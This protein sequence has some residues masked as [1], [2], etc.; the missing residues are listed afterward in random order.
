MS[1]K[2]RI[3]CDSEAHVEV[4][5]ERWEGICGEKLEAAVQLILPVATSAT[6]EEKAS[7]KKVAEEDSPVED[8]EVTTPE[9][10]S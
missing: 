6:C 10:Q 1:L 8:E 2:I 7:A 4:V 5:Q 3:R 9:K